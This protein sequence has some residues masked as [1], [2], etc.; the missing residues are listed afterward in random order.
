MRAENVTQTLHS[1]SRSVLT[2]AMI[3]PPPPYNFC[4][5]TAGR[6]ASLDGLRLRDVSAVSVVFV[7]V[8]GWVFFFF[9]G[10]GG[11]GVRSW[12]DYV[13]SRC[14]VCHTKSSDQ[15][16]NNGTAFHNVG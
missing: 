13:L 7:V 5:V 15:R 14:P 3:T 8:V 6:Q 9:G 12:C 2:P 11:G 16:H 4:R 1:S 10:G